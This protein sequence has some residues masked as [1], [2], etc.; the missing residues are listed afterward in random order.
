M[1]IAYCI[2]VCNEYLE[3]QK[4]INHM[5]KYVNLNEDEIIVLCDSTK[6]NEKVIGFCKYCSDTYGINFVLDEFQNHFSDWK[7]KFKTLSKS[8]YIFQIDADE[9]PNPFLLHN[10][11]TLLTNNANIELFWIPRENYVDGITE[12]HII[13]WKM[14]LDDKSRINFPDYQARLFKNKPKIKWVNKVH[15]IIS[16]TDNQAAL[17]PE[18]QFSLLHTKSIDKQEQQNNYYDTL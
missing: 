9:L 4:L 6:T 2:T 14:T 13:K 10:L 5:I 11:K 7:N 3:I 16:G 17:P 1:K 18:E 12:E 15:E 8:D